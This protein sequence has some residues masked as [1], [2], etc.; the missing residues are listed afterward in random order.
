M[1]DP[2]V[3]ILCDQPLRDHW[4]RPQTPQVYPNILRTTL[5]SV[6]VTPPALSL[7]TAVPGVSVG[8]ALG[9]IDIETATPPT[10]TLDSAIPAISVIASPRFTINQPYWDIPPPRKVQPP[11]VF[12]N[13]SVLFSAT[14]P[15]GF[16]A[17]WVRQ[18]AR[19]IG[20][21]I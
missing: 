21:G 8:T 14:P 18:S 5:T 16:R 12:P 10:L 7:D 6:G 17:A 2:F 1:A 4:P 11:Y 15:A 3:V 9:G 19:M 13:L 20:G